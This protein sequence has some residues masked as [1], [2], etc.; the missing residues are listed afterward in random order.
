[1]QAGEE[2]GQTGGPENQTPDTQQA[3]LDRARARLERLL[4]GRP[5]TVYGVLAAGVG[6]LLVLLL[7]IWITAGGGGSDDKAPPCFALDGATARDA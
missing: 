2:A 4:G 6:V 3:G 7:I 5:L 1:M